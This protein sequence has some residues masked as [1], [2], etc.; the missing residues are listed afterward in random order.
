MSNHRWRWLAS[1]AALLVAVA[2][3][4][5]H[6]ARTHDKP[7][8]RFVSTSDYLPRVAA[9]L[10]LPIAKARAPVVV[11]VPGGSWLS[12]DRKGLGPLADD[13]AAHGVVAV[14]A[15][16]RAVNAGVRF[17]VPVADIV[18]AVDFA[19]DRARRA[20][21]VGGPV[22]VL[23]HS[24]GAH[25]AALA[26]LRAARFRHDCSY[27]TARI[28]GFIGLAGPYDITKL[29]DVAQPLFGSTAAANPTLWKEGN[30]TE[31]VNERTAAPALSVLLAHGL[32]DHVVSP[33]FSQTFSE[34]LKDAGHRVQLSMVSGASHVTIFTPKVIASTVI[35]WLD[36]LS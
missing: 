5:V 35:G 11:L 8:P 17:P 30:P 3:F 22:V 16:Y 25:L 31:W 7:L 27:P 32:A 26:A 36:T 10:Y 20:G 12:A 34:D 19:A 9:D 33:W 15:T 23:G 24:S 21:F 6:Q 2:V 29:A 18:C 14:N 13:L 4:V 28:D 1:A